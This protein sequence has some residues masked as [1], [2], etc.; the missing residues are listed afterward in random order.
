MFLTPQIYSNLF[1]YSRAEASRG[2]ES[3][4]A[5]TGATFT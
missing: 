4:S 3:W 1:N 5:L 2:Q